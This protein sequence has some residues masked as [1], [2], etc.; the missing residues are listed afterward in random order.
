MSPLRG[1]PGSIIVPFRL[2]A[3][4]DDQPSGGLAAD[5]GFAATNAGES[6]ARYSAADW[7]LIWADEFDRPGLPDP[8]KWDYE[9]GFVRNAEPQFYTK[10]RPENVTVAD[11]QLVITARSEV[12]PDGWTVGD[13]FLVMVS[14]SDDQE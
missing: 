13:G 8:A 12:D 9:V 7:K 2:R 14:G 5:T 4:Q 11:G 10:A 3:V 1:F 6:L